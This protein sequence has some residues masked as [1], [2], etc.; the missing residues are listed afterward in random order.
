MSYPFKFFPEILKIFVRKYKMSNVLW[1]FKKC[2][3]CF[4]YCP[5][6]RLASETICGYYEKTKAEERIPK[7]NRSIKTNAEDGKKKNKCRRRQGEIKMCL[8]NSASATRFLKE[9]LEKSLTKT[10]I[11]WKV[12]E[13]VCW[14]NQFGSGMKL[15]P[16]YY[17]DKRDI[18]MKPGHVISN[19]DN[20]G[21]RDDEQKNFEVFHGIHVWTNR[22]KAERD[23][24]CVSVYCNSR[25]N[26]DYVVIPVICSLKDF[27]AA[28]T[29]EDAV[30]MKVKITKQTWEKLQKKE[31]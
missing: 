23:V 15:N 19:R 13:R 11:L 26:G 1:D 3:K 2:Q 16:V 17:Y 7:S 4:Y 10:I 9:K 30:F 14:K 20:K 5:R 6:Q 22:W 25:A 12:Y 24:K 8:L 31:K 29:S 27:V 18:V 28:G 21:L